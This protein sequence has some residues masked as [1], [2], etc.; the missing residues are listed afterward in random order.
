[1]GIV[2]SVM[3]E[4]WR[5]VGYPIDKGEQTH[6]YIKESDTEFTQR[7]DRSY[8]VNG[9]STCKVTEEETRQLVEKDETVFC[10]KCLRYLEG[11]VV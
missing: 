4:N 2:P 3:A 5:Y 9:D 7:C 8:V 11:L 10:P 6:F 1:M